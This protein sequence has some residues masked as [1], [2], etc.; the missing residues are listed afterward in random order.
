[1]PSSE[2]RVQVLEFRKREFVT[3]V[4]VGVS[5]FRGFAGLATE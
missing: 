1:M 2:Y 5:V 3:G 4:K